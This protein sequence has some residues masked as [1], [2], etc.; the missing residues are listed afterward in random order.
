MGTIRFEKVKLTYALHTFLRHTLHK[1]VMFVL[2]QEQQI[3]NLWYG[4]ENCFHCQSIRKLFP[5]ILYCRQAAWVC[6]LYS[7]TGRLKC[8]LCVWN[9][10]H[11]RSISRN[12]SHFRRIFIRLNYVNIAKNTYVQHWMLMKILTWEQCGIL[13]VP[14][15]APV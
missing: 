11:A 3:K 2:Q 1:L 4:M 14:Q 12:L 13:M 7:C 5:S 9:I 15:T 10:N 8:L 6:R